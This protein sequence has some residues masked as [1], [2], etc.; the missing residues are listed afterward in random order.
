MMTRIVIV[1]GGFAGVKC[2]KTL[3]RRLS[4]DRHEI[5]LF[6]HENHMMFHPLLA[7]VAG[8][9]LTPDSVA[10]PLRRMLPGVRCRTE[11]VRAID[12]DR[13]LVEYEA[14]DGQARTLDYEHVV[15]AC[16]LAVNLGSVPGMA[17][18]GFPLK[19]I[20][21]A[22]ALRHH[23]M[24]QLEKAEVCDDEARR[25]W[26]LS[27]VV[28]G[29]GYSG[30]EAA[31]ELND[32]V[33][34]SCRFYQGVREE[35]LSVTLIHSREEILPEIGPT[36]R[37]FARRK[38]EEAGI[39]VLLN[40]RVA[41][42]S[43]EGVRLTSGR[44]ASGATIVCTVGTMVGP[45]VERLQV[46]KERGLLLTE[47]DMRLA[48]RADAWAAGD[49]ARI[50]NAWDGRPSPPTGQFAERQGRQVAQNIA[51]VLAGKPTRPFRFRPLG[52][53]CSI[54]GKTAVAEI[55][56][57]RMSGFLAWFVWRGVYLFKLPSWAHR[58][59][60]GFDW[61]W[62]LVYSR[63]IAHPR[64]NL[65][66][67]V[68]HAFYEEGDFVF[69]QGDPASDFYVIERGEAE[70]LRSDQPGGA[71]RTLAVLGEGEFFGE[72]ALIDHKPRSASVRA[73]TPLEVVVVGCDVFG[74]ISRSLT[75]FR[76][77]LG[78]AMRRR[79][80]AAPRPPENA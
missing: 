7:E 49:C 64:A 57:M 60:V 26:Y 51:W 52:Q 41:T 66:N 62:Q 68:S 76:E 54:G 45:V 39:S 14:H 21:D 46:P 74:Q 72:M 33:R 29:G 50:V 28:V 75:P 40:E 20:G 38:M 16:G 10:A 79:A 25:R 34:G 3:R 55:L 56:G 37:Q 65:T 78:D 13:K 44:M 24:Q 77:L 35:D 36:L 80:E 12:L 43:P 4:P 59:K 9:S 61:A 17:D 22:I 63:D 67:R 15:I 48:G 1:G 42:A 71:M 58:I 69:H 6:N 11:D 73:R 32:L 23:V 18:H 47:P 70:V 19:T 2:A 8:G 5:V 31:G 27:F 53:L 30:V